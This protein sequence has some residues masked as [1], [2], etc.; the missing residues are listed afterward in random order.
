MFRDTTIKFL[1]S[2][3]NL[4]VLSFVTHGESLN[5][6]D[7]LPSWVPLW[8]CLP[9]TS[10]GFDV[11][12]FPFQESRLLQEEIR[13][14]SKEIF[15][16]VSDDDRVLSLRGLQVDVVEWHSESI[17]Y[18]MIP[19]GLWDCGKQEH[20][21]E[22]IWTDLK[23]HYSCKSYD[24]KLLTLFSFLL[25]SGTIRATK[26]RINEHNA[27][28]QAWRLKHSEQL[29]PKAGELF[30]GKDQQCFS[31]LRE[32]AEGGNWEQFVSNAFR[33]CNGRKM[34][35]TKNGHLGVGPM[36]MRSGDILSILFAARTPFILRPV[37]DQYIFVGEAY[38]HGLMPSELMTTWKSQH[39][40]RLFKIV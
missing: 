1:R 21:L 37:G 28:F 29:Q 40:S 3:G 6:Q 23:S 16:G 39:R 38:L 12:V 30:P 31:M 32:T 19:P 14:I 8:D 11:R 34:F 15:I 9:L 35:R 27:N 2:M 13:D 7:G 20:P 26:D 17:I 5:L 24:G 36:A 10:T 33:A 22:K 18:K 4:D 25:T